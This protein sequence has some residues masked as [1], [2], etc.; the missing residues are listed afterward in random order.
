MDRLTV[1]ERI[2]L[3][4]TAEGIM[5]R[6][7]GRTVMGNAKLDQFHNHSGNAPRY[8]YEGRFP[9]PKNRLNTEEERPAPEP[10]TVRLAPEKPSRLLK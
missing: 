10:S 9:L 6:A 7:Q 2:L 5:T 4:R 1:D 8:S 3:R